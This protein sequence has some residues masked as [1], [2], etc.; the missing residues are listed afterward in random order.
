MEWWH[1]VI[2]VPV[3]IVAL[4]IIGFLVGLGEWMHT[5]ITEWL[6]RK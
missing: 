2:L 5:L 1:W 3:A 4:V 6:F